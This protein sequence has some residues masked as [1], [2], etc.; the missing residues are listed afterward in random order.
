MQSILANQG[1]NLER[2][3]TRNHLG[4]LSAYSNRQEIVSYFRE[5][6]SLRIHLNHHV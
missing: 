5:L 1:K 4:P 2:Q 3:V 6:K